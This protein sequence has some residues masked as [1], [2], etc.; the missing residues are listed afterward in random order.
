[1]FGKEVILVKEQGQQGG[2]VFESSRR[3]R[4]KGERTHN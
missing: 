4:G 1:M 3:G 2:V